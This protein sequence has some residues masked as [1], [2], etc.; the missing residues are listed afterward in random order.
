VLKQL[1]RQVCAANKKLDKYKLVTFTWGNVSGI[2]R[3]RKLIVIKPSGIPYRELTPDDMVV[4]SLKGKVVE[5]ENNP[6]SDTA[7]HLRLYEAFPSIGGI[8]HT[9]SPWATVFAQ[10]GQCIPAYGT[11]HAD[12]F[13]G[14]IPCTRSLTGTEVEGEYEWETGNVIAEAFSAQNIDPVAMPG[15]LVKNHGPFTWG[16]NPMQAVRNSVVMEEIAKMTFYTKQLAP[17]TLPVPQSL[18]DRHYYRKNGPMATY[19]Q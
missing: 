19:G 12:Y 5:G 16:E 17:D 7:T 3:E 1:R 11:T 13:Y 15:V 4:V 2:D 6:S 14:T 9:H 18:L 8:V 10:G